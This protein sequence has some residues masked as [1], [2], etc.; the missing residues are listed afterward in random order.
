[1]EQVTL[2]GDAY[3]TRHAKAPADRAP[4]RIAAEMITPYPPGM[5]VVLL[6]ERL[7][8]PVLEC[9]TTGLAERGRGNEAAYR[10][11]A[12]LA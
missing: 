3:C 2:P 1:M 10:G 12:S 6:C 8:E 11:Y 5:P 4:G 7:T 9:L